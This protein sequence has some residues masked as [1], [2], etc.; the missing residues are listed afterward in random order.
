[1]VF[2]I[3]T[4]R[5]YRVR[6]EIGLFR[7]GL[8]PRDRERVRAE[9]IPSTEFLADAMTNEGFAR[10]DV[11]P[12]PH[13]RSGVFWGRAVWNGTTGRHDLPAMFVEVEPLS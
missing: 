5:F 9:K 2:K 7:R 6:L 11:R 3:E 8:S 1:M 4:G 13:Q 10:P 12:D